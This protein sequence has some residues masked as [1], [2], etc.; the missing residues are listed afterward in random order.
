MGL[1]ETHLALQPLLLT[2]VGV[3]HLVQ[4]LPII[5]SVRK[6][7]KPSALRHVAIA[8]T[9]TALVQYV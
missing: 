6:P 4:E 3:T 5:S 2:G 7:P 8:E 9:N 1:G